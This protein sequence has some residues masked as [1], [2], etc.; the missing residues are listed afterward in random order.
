MNEWTKLPGLDGRPN[1]CACCPPIR[2]KASLEK[3]IAVGFGS[4]YVTKDGDEVWAE[5]GDFDECWRFSDAEAAALKDP[6]HDWRVTM[7]GPLHGEVY[8]RQGIGEW[9][10][11]ESNQGFA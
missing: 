8:Q 9:I 5:S 1:P 4:A 7:F 3:V 2:A 10:L 6:D 11:V